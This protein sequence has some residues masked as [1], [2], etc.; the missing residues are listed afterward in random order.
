M[1]QQ[2]VKEYTLRATEIPVPPRLN[3]TN[4]EHSHTETERAQKP[5]KMGT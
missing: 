4:A 3:F 2:S 1:C 5:I